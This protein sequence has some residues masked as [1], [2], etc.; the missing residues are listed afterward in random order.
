MELKKGFLRIVTL[1]LAVF[2]VIP[3][4]PA[5]AATFKDVPS[6]HW[7][8]SYIEEMSKEGI[9]NGYPDGTFKP[10][11]TLTYLETMQL[12][13]KLLDMSTAEVNSSKQKYS[14][15]VNDYGVPNWAQ[16]AVM[17]C[18]YKGVIS[19]VELKLAADNNMIKFGTNK[20][21]RRLDVSVYMAKAMGLKTKPFVVLPYKDASKIDAS[22]H[23]LIDALIEA[24]VLNA[25]GT[26]KGYY[27]PNSPLLREQMA[28][29]MSVA[30]NYLDKKP[31]TPKTPEVPKTETDQ[32]IGTISKIDKIGDKYFVVVKE[33]SGASATYIVDTST[34]IRLDGKLTT[35]TSLFKG[36][37]VEVTVK[38]GST[39]AVE[40][41]AEILKA[42]IEG[43][44]VSVTP[45][46]NKISVEYKDGNTN[47]TAD[48]IVKNS[49]DITLDG[50]DARL[51]DL[52]K[53]D[54]VILYTENNS[55]VQIEA[56]AMSGEIEG[57]IRELDTEIV[58][59]KTIYY[60]T[61]ENPKGNKVEYELNEDVDIYR[62]GKR[63]DFK[64]LRTGDEV[65]L[66][67]E[68]GLVTEVDADVVEKE[69]VG[70]ISAISTR[71]N[72]GTEITIRN[73][74]TDKDETYALSKDVYIEVDDKYA[75]VTSLNVGYYVELVIGSDE[76]IELE[77]D[78][79]GAESMVR[80]T[81]RR[82]S[83]RRDEV[84]LEVISSDLSGYGYGDE[85]TITID[86]DTI[87][88]EGSY[89]NL[90]IDDLERNLEIIVFGYY[91]GYKFKVTEIN[92]R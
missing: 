67:M 81:I 49:A 66:V 89:R 86:K 78:S 2:M 62:N 80:A 33:K 37:T 51:L 31:E 82:V 75:S 21:V 35:A 36:Q 52:K 10:R 28:K 11:E 39:S 42:K 7:A 5:F 63:A 19:E 22:Y 58:S 9:I 40:V 56:T 48:L 13:S 18:L 50:K 15:I 20:R 87:I 68:A 54:E 6:S 27:E 92:I 29:M 46:T 79:R 72:S 53:G 16:E 73:S 26:G 45:V 25:N 76:I 64:D 77:A 32:I 84:D 41:D 70:Y 74:D 55:V 30:F 65:E 44:I 1:V 24:G 59:K 61:V 34:T 47:R 14:K 71:L 4:M 23:G 8:Y 69:I 17:K 43:T 3:S 85:M 83:T 57:V 90:T 88:S 91:D 12:L 38:K 60:I